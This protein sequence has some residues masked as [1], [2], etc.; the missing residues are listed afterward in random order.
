M[1]LI[2]YKSNF[3]GSGS[4][5][6]V[7]K[8]SFNCNDKAI[9]KDTVAK[10]FSSKLEWLYEIKENEIINKIDKNYKFTVKM[11]NYCPINIDYINN[12]VANINK[13]SIISNNEN[14]YQII[15][16][17]GGINLKEL[18]L[19]PEKIDL[20]FFFK[21]FLNIF[22]GLYEIELNGLC[23]RDI[24]IEN[25]LFNGNKISLIDFGLMVKRKEIYDFNNLLIYINN[26]IYYYP[27]EM[28]LYASLKLNYSIDINKLNSINLLKL[29]ETY[30]LPD[31]KHSNLLKNILK[32]IKEDTIKFANEITK[33]QSIEID[34]FLN[35]DT[36]LLG[37]ALLEIVFVIIMNNLANEFEFH[38]LYLISKMIE[39][40][41]YKRISMKEA[42]ELYFI[43]I[44]SQ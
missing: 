35:I 16:E 20:K 42:K 36:Y 37:I 40:D 3:I 38:L 10:L 2:N 6:C 28:K 4:Y 7:I 18:F 8:P 26:N 27:N 22:D 31:N 34:K 12:N 33:L 19:Y 21:K 43:L 23:H 29:I 1:N 14:V 15:Y 17:D 41:P 9:Q 39:I 5:G 44:N 13:C 30:N 11:I 32:K 24:K 25:L